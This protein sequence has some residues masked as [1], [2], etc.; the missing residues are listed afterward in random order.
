LGLA[1]ISFVYLAGPL[2]VFLGRTKRKIK[3]N[4]DSGGLGRIFPSRGLR[5]VGY[6]GG[7]NGNL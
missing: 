2:C 6:K 5:N 4:L 1:L 3:N 7:N